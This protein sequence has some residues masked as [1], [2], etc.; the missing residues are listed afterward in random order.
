[1]IQYICYGGVAQLGERCIRIAE[2]RSSILPVST[3]ITYKACA[4]YCTGF[5]Y[6]FKVVSLYSVHPGIEFNKIITPG[7]ID[8][9][10]AVRAALGSKVGNKEDLRIIS[11]TDHHVVVKTVL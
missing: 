7:V 1:M 8:L 2:V 11:Q 5:M 10:V 6:S 3:K 9:I 4:T